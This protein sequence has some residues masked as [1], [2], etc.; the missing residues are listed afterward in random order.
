MKRYYIVI[1]ISFTLLI[2]DILYAN[3]DCLFTQNCLCNCNR[4]KNLADRG[5][6]VNCDHFRVPKDINYKIIMKKDN[7]KRCCF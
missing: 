5:I 6:C 7:I 4:Y 1:L 2:E 3:K